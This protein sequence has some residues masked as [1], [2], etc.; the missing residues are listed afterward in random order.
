MNQDLRKKLLAA[1][2]RA[3]AADATLI[4]MEG[5][6][7]ETRAVENAFK[8]KMKT[9]YEKRVRELESMQQDFEQV[10]SLPPL[11]CLLCSWRHTWFWEALP[12]P[13]RRC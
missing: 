10:L 1:M 13:V 8:M 2:R 5:E 12:H 9:L 6:R 4:K 11:P 3:E 7:E